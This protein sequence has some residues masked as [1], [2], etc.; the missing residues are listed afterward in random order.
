[1]LLWL[2]PL[3]DETLSRN[4]GP[5]ALASGLAHYANDLQ[6]WSAHRFRV[7]PTLVGR[8][9]A[10]AV[11]ALVLVPIAAFAARR[12]WSAFVLGGTVSILGL[13]LVP[14][15][16]VHF[17]DLVS[18]SQSRRAVGFLPFA[19]AFAGGLALLARSILVLPAALAAGIVLQHE[20]P[21]DFGYGLRHGGP[22]A[23]T[24]I[25]FVGG[26]AGIVAS[27]WLRRYSVRERHGRAAIAAWLF[28]LPIAVHGFR[29]WDPLRTE[30]P[31]ALSPALARELRAVPPR[32]V[33][34]A[35]PRQSYGIAAA[36]PVYVVA[37]P[38]THVAN[39]EANRPYERVRDVE[40]WLARNDP[41]VLRKYRPTWAVRRGHLYRLSP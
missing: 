21:G 2:R 24:W 11:A 22:A 8:S 10:V 12:R 9:G 14:T 37:A 13:T 26:A 31:Y 1:V 30:D 35:T 20:W 6:V 27:I 25:A 5:Q 3:A 41:A 4:P 18:L 32:A 39:T 15:L 33:V 23:A 36:A 19:F 38:P 29:S 34:I 7:E 28:V 40:R 16:F 17:S